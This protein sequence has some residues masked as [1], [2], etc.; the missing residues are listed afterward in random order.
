[1][2]GVPMAGFVAIIDIGFM[3][4]TRMRIRRA[5]AHAKVNIGIYTQAELGVCGSSGKRRR[6]TKRPS[7]GNTFD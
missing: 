1:M 3:P 5:D 6:E 7:S 2:A 4:V